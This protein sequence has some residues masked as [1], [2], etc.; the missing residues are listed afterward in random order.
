MTREP[1]ACSLSAAELP[2]R[3]DQIRALGHDGLISIEQEPGRAVL[4]FGAGAE[5]RQRIDRF[6]EAERRCCA[7]LDFRVED[8]GDGT[9]VT[10]AAPP[11]GEPVLEGLAELLSTPA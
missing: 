9:R 2:A 7:F 10:I 1:I 11:G 4:R 8:D 6:V 3:Q 5:L